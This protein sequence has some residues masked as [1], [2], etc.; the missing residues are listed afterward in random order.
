MNT[1][2]KARTHQGF[3]L[4][5]LLIVLVIVSLIYA[6]GFSNLSFTKAKLKAI[7][8]INLK[9]TI[10]K[11]KFFSGNATLMCVNK[12]RKCYLRKGLTSKF[13][14]YANKINLHNIKAY[15]I[16]KSDALV[17]IEYQ[18]F[19]D[20]R[21]CLVI[22][23]YDNG[24]STQIILEDN[25]GAYFLPAFFGKSQKFASIEEAKSHWLKSSRLISNSGEYY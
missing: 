18:R 11:S 16:D 24:S 22:D 14:P 13:E 20:Q 9:E 5:E 8:P 1:S 17:E 2:K 25:N 12:C 3:S 23:F 4:I 6:V 19:D 7:T 10:V 21:I 15:V